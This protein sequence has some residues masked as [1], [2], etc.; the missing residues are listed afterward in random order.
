VRQDGELERVMRAQIENNQRAI[1]EVLAEYIGEGS[2]L[3]QVLTP[4]ESN[5]FLAGLRQSLETAL[6]GQSGQIL[7]EFSLDNPEGAL[8][9]LVRELKARHGELTGDLAKQI[10]SVVG[11]F[12]LDKDDS[13]LSRLVKRVELAQRQISSEFS[14]DAEN[15][16]LARLKRELL[17]VLEQ[18]RQRNDAFQAQ[19]Q[20]ALSNMR[21]RKEEAARSTQHGHS[22]QDEGFRLVQRLCEQAGDVAED[23]GDTTGVIA[24]CKT[25]DCVVTLGADC[26]AAGSRMVVEFKE[27]ASYTLKATLEE[28]DTARK[29]RGAE[30]G[31]F[32]HSRRTAPAGMSEFARHGNAIVVV[33]DAEDEA[34]DVVLRAGLMVAKALCVRAGAQAQGRTVELAQMDAAVRAIEKQTEK[35]Q[36]I[37]IK[38]NT[39]R[40]SADTIVQYAEIGERE[41]LR[42]IAELDEH[43]AGLRT[44]A[45]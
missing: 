4:D 43:L 32:V 22:F 14:L 19:V 16:A 31:L 35:F 6:S 21:A 38:C 29:N 30:F 34:S 2:P 41:M 37:R 9:R 1:T 15:S 10:A 36:A 26:V 28:L 45:P 23:V 24:R 44:Q 20:E 8:A 11:E 25:G 40:S 12:S 5:R 7:R 17:G 13:A 39:I 3:L 18:Q 27:D 42:Q 33:W